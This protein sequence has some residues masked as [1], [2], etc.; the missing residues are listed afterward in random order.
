MPHESEHPAPADSLQE[1]NKT[2]QAIHK[3]L[4][5]ILLIVAMQVIGIVGIALLLVALI[6]SA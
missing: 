4:Y 2:L 1:V 3:R 6:K 5:E